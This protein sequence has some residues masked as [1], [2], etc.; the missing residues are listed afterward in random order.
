M[1]RLLL[2]LTFIFCFSFV[3][4]QAPV[5][6]SQ[7]EISI[8]TVGPGQVLND[9]FG[10]SAFRI[11]DAKR[12]IDVVYGYGAYDFDTPNFYLKFAQGRLSYLMSKT[13]F[14]RFYGIYKYYNRQ[15]DEQVLN[16]DTDQKQRFYTY[17]LHNYKPK[18]RS[19]L[20][21]FFFDNCATKIR[22][23]CLSE[24][25]NAIVFNTPES[26]E[27]AT[28]RT[29]IQN[30]LQHNSWGSF[31]INI[32]LGAV[33]DTPAAANEH[34]FL[35]ENIYSFFN[36]ATFKDSNIPLVKRK[37]TL[38]Q[39]QPTASNSTF[40]LSPF[41][42]LSLLAFVILFYTYRD[43]KHYSSSTFI[44]ISIFIITGLIGAIILLLWFATDHKGTHNNYNLLWA[45]VLNLFTVFQFFKA[46]PAKWFVSYLKFCVILLALMVFH[47][48]TG[49]Q[50]FAL[51]LIPLLIAIAIRYLFLIKRLS[52]NSI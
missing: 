51:P 26:Y 35:P 34:M 20:Y 48:C 31:G 19:Y 1:M 14:S 27:V 5:L 33:I 49:V 9:A 11:K 16:L 52:V 8:L 4:S 25:Q 24:T 45:N 12:D 2:A 38:L 10:H 23:I 7:A 37:A 36:A 29:L 47:W 21:D 28:F 44:D 41:F 50:I 32:A 43:Y 40:F 3:Q 46:T 13:S 6:S 30:N 39:P 42:I 17:L 15:I 18:N 22:D